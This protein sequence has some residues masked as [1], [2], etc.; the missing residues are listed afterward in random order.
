MILSEGY[1]DG[2]VIDFYY[3]SD[4]YGEGGVASFNLSGGYSEGGVTSFN[5]SDGYGDGIGD[6]ERD[7]AAG[8]LIGE[9]MSRS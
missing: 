6:G 7:W 2:A 4:S 3:F 1:G 8:S 5:L 9:L